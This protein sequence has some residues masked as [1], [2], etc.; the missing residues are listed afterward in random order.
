[1]PK[2]HLFSVVLLTYNRLPL[3]T[4]AVDALQRQTYDNLEIILV[5]NSSS[6]GTFEYLSQLAASD[7]RVKLLHFEENQFSL[8]DPSKPVAVCANAGL[9]I[10][11]GDYVWYQS[12]DDMLSDDYVKRMVALFRE[13]PECTTAPLVEALSDSRERWSRINLTNLARWSARI[14]SIAENGRTTARRATTLAYAQHDTSEGYSETPS[15]VLLSG[16]SARLSETPL[17]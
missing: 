17:R 6:D 4:E 12:D 13:N 8:D 3:L 7:D 15:C 2:P 14:A 5:D 10:A 11:M 1:V 9:E 16:T